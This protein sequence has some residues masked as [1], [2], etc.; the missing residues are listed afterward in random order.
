[1][2]MSLKRH[3]M[4]EVR[5]RLLIL[6]REPID[7]LEERLKRR[8][9]PRVVI[10]DSF[11]YSGLSYPA[12]KELKERHPKKLFVFISHAEGM[13]PAGRTARKV[14]YDA[15]V[16]I[17]V[18][19]FKAWCKSRLWNNRANPYTIWGKAPPKHG[20]KMDK[21]SMR[22]KN[23]LYRLRKKGVK[24]NTRERCV[25]LPYGSEPD[26]IAQV[27]RLRREYD[28]VVQFEIV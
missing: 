11:Q 10:I 26:N 2:Q 17:M 27:R 16:K 8:G 21:K 3:R 23:L 12:Y 22:R 24:V 15:D 28:F 14:E 20:W 5:K 9:S 18:S 1:M 19:G 7:Q 6:D 25:Y 13:H 4:E